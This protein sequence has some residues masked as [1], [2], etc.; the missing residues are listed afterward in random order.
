MTFLQKLQE[1]TITNFLVS[2]T[3]IWWTK[4]ENIITEMR[5]VLIFKTDVLGTTRERHLPDVTLGRLKDVF[6]TFLQ[7]PKTK[8]QLFSV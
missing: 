3:H 2:N 7:N 5:F 8:K 6:R 4:T 1:C